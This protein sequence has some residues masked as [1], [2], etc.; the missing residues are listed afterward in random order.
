[1]S[2]FF[3]KLIE[4]DYIFMLQCFYLADKIEYIPQPLYNYIQYNSQSTTFN[5]S[6]NNFFLDIDKSSFS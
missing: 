1:M 4:E 5:T 6:P 3:I 2:F